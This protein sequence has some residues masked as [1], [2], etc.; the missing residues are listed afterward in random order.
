MSYLEDQKQ[1]HLKRVLG[2][3]LLFAI[4]GCTVLIFAA[5]YLSNILTSALK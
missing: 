5:N 4:L 2:F 1:E 3:T